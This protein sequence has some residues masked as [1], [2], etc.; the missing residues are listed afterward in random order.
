MNLIDAISSFDKIRP[1]SFDFETKKTWVL[2]M[3]SEIRGFAAL[4]SGKE[5]DMDFYTKENP[6][7]FL[8]DTG[9]DIYVF[10]LISMADLANGEYRLYN[11]SS[12]YFNSVF[13]RWKKRYRAQNRPKTNI[14][15]KQ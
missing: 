3:E 13:D 4:H 10:Y 11:V 9:A 2:N 5:A 6:K 15:I 12:T 8:D 1:N 7:L 14:N